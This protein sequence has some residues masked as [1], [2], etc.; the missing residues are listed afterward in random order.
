LIFDECQYVYG[1]AEVEGRL[2]MWDPGV[3]RR[4][5]VA[6]AMAVLVTVAPLAGGLAVAAPAAGSAGSMALS[7]SGF[8]VANDGRLYQA[9]APG[10][11][12]GGG[13]IRLSTA[14]LAPPNAGVSAVR[15]PD[16]NLALFLIGNH[17]GLIGVTTNH[18][19]SGLSIFNAGSPGL[20]TPGVKLTAITAPDGVHV[21]FPGTGGAIHAASFGP[22]VRPQSLVWRTSAPGLAS[23]TAS[24]AAGWDP[25]GVTGAVFTG[26]DGGLR[27]VW[28]NGSGLSSVVLSPAGL[29]PSGAG[30]AMISGQ[31]PAQAFFAG[32]NGTLWL[33]AA[34]PQPI[35]W[36]PQALSNPSSV[37]AGAQL[38]A[39]YTGPKPDPLRRAAVF[40]AAPDGAVK[41]AS[42]P[43]QGWLAPAAT[44]PAGAAP[45]GA[46]LSMVQTSDDYLHVAWCGNDLLWWWLRWRKLVPPPPPPPWLGE[47]FSIRP[48]VPIRAGNNVSVVMW[49]I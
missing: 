33:F 44:T 28:R 42:N 3:T 12:S 38:T 23:A 8:L 45:P 4:R 41:V 15:Q 46:A 18:G 34:G 32:N 39:V 5:T 26:L 31:G 24:V 13:L 30:V 10:G 29:A 11:S 19:A 6:M 17:G 7:L 1:L 47:R 16:G 48:N 43:G 21:F 35:P 9:P 2:L 27:S 36:Q 40:F 22:Q 14:V 37:P 20:A 49:G 25:A